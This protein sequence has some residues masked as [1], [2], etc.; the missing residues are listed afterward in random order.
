M[1]VGSDIAQ[2]GCVPSILRNHSLRSTTYDVATEMSL[3]RIWEMTPLTFVVVSRSSACRSVA[4][5]G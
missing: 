5:T 4:M 3:V 2:Y 1:R